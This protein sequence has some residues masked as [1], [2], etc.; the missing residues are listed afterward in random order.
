MRRTPILYVFLSFE[1]D[2]LFWQADNTR[3]EQASKAANTK[4]NTR[5]MGKTSFHKIKM[6]KSNTKY[7]IYSL[8]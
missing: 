4:R 7:V 8:L 6:Y 2:G 1:P 3:A 5:F